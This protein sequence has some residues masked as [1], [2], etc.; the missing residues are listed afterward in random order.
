MIIR[1]FRH[2]PIRQLLFLTL[3]FPSRNVRLEA[4]PEICCAHACVDDGEGDQ[5]DG[6][7]SESGKGTAN[8]IVEAVARR[9]ALVHADKF[10]E[11]IGKASEVEDLD[12]SVSN[13]VVFLG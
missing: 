1:H 13:L 4:P 8:G 10:K 3:D 2:I 9:T 7:D 11:E 5:D 12:G 6:H